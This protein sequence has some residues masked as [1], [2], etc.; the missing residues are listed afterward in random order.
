MHICV[1]LTCRIRSFRPV[2]LD[3]GQKTGK[4]KR[5]RFVQ[6][7]PTM[8]LQ[9]IQEAIIWNLQEHMTGKRC[10]IMSSRYPYTCPRGTLINI[11]HLFAARIMRGSGG[12]GASP[13]QGFPED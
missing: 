6:V 12:V 4:E 5:K 9:R 7:V 11:I 8:I 10:V 3:G 13:K 1:D 2:N